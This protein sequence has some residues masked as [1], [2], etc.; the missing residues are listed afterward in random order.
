MRIQASV[1]PGVPVR[2][3][4]FSIHGA[5]LRTPWPLTPGCELTLNVEDARVKAIVR[6]S[7][8]DIAGCVFWHDGASRAVV[9]RIYGRLAGRMGPGSLSS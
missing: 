3:L 2:V 7:R 4:D 5:R 6:W 1:E 9:E 8:R